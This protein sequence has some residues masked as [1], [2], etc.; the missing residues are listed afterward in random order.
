MEGE[1]NGCS[2]RKEWSYE[3]HFEGSLK[4]ICTDC[5]CNSRVLVLVVFS[6]LT[7]YPPQKR[8]LLS[9]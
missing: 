1:R 4:A 7:Y 5:D 2:F 3:V 9:G 6:E 8:A